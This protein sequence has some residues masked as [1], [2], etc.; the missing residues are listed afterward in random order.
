ME[1]D[2]CNLGFLGFEVFGFFGSELV[3]FRFDLGILELFEIS[4]LF[5]FPGLD[6]PSVLSFWFFFFAFFF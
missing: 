2:L 1:W 4:D 6:F 3:L 5:L